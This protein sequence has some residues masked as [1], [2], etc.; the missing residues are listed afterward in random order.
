MLDSANGL[1]LMKGVLNSRHEQLVGEQRM[2][3]LATEVRSARA[4][5]RTVSR[6]RRLIARAVL[7]FR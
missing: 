4:T 2:H 3:R 6:P 1:V 7:A 5:D